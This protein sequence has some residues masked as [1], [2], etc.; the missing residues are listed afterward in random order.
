MANENVKSSAS[1]TSAKCKPRLLWERAHPRQKERKSQRQTSALYCES[2]HLCVHHGNQCGVP[3]TTE[4]RT[5]VPPLCHSCVFTQKLLGRCTLEILAHVSSS[6]FPITR[7][8]SQPGCPPTEERAKKI[9]YVYTGK[10]FQ[11]F[12]CFVLLFSVKSWPMQEKEYN[13]VLLLG[14]I[15][16]T[17]N[18]LWHADPRFK[19]ICMG[20]GDDLLVKS[21][22]C[23]FMG[24]EFSF[25]HPHR[26]THK[27]PTTPV[28]GDPVSFFVLPWHI[29]TNTHTHTN[30]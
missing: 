6:V 27:Q 8:W 4:N 29:H 24:P 15:R 21:N 17:Q 9:Q 10:F 26:V 23:S 7:N 11:Q 25:Q 22:F 19:M 20:L 5:A 30:T 3:Q 16:Q 13:W 14:E 1:L 2:A 28:P 18:G 12:F